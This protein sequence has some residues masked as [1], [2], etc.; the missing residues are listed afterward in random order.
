M[1]QSSHENKLEQQ[2]VRYILR[3]NYQDPENAAY[4]DRLPLPR[5][6]RVKLL[7]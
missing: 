1:F 4:Q 6:G 7:P 3:R 5:R 2:P